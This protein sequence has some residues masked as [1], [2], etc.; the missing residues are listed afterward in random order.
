[1][2]GENG[3]RVGPTVVWARKEGG[4]VKEEEQQ[5]TTHK[6]AVEDGKTVPEPAG[7]TGVIRLPQTF[8]MIDGP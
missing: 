6:D 1:M 7:G 8:D 4:A 2:E 3:V 5:S